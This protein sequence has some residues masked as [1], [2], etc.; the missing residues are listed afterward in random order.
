MEHEL[1]ITEEVEATNSIDMHESEMIG[2]EI[3]YSGDDEDIRPKQHRQRRPFYDREKIEYA[4]ELMQNGLSNKEMSM[5]LELSIANVRK[6]K[7]NILNGTV[8]EL[9]DDSAEHY[10]KLSN[11][12]ERVSF[13][14]LQNSVLTTN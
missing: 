11:N 10:S 6:L 4:T 7:V 1:P 12:S 8:D 2:D 9:I 14:Q 13:F 3:Y 5:L